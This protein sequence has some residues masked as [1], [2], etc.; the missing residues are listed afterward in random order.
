MAYFN[1][2]SA[3]QHNTRE[4]QNRDYSVIQ[5]QYRQSE[6]GFADQIE[7]IPEENLHGNSEVEDEGMRFS[8]GVFEEPAR[9]MTS[10]QEPVIEEREPSEREISEVGEP[11]EPEEK[12]GHFDELLLASN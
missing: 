4:T 8:T 10:V 2:L 12:T 6:L 5:D 9:E 11:E 3:S 1:G 7:V